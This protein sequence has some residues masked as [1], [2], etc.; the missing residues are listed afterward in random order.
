VLVLNINLEH[1]SLV[2]VVTKPW[3]NDRGT[4]VPFTVKALDFYILQTLTKSSGAHPASFSVS[5]WV[6]F[7]G[8]KAARELS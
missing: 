4:V 3:S 5:T 6:A 1:D 2:G 8:G 7:T